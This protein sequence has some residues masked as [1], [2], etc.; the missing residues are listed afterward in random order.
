MNNTG[1]A[2]DD[3][4]LI[5]DLDGTLVKTDLLIESYFSAAT[6]S[7]WHHITVLGTLLR[8][9][10]QLK[11]YLASSST[12]D[13]GL[14]PYDE[15][16]LALIS[17]A[18][19]E[20]RRVYLATAS[21]QRHAEGVAAHLG[22]FDG[23]FSSDAKTNLSGKKKARLLVETFGARCFDYAGN[24]PADMAVWEE[25]RKAY[26]ANSSP[27]LARKV[28]RLGIPVEHL[29]RRTPVLR[30][31]L[32][33]LRV[34]QYAKNV[35]VFVP[36]LTAHAYSP[37]FLLKALLAFVAFCLC[38]SSVYILNDLLDLDA[39]RQHPG[40]RKRAFASGEI[41]I[42]HGIIAAP[43]LLLLAFSCAFLTSLPFAGALAG[44]FALTLA[45]SLTLKRKLLLDVV[46]LALLY[47]I[48]V[49]AGAVA[50]PVMVSE[51]LLA[52][53]MF[54]FTALA[55]VKRYVELSLRLDK[56]LPDPANRNYQLADLPIVG[57]L[58]AASGFNA[59]TIFALYISSPAVSTL[60]RHPERLWLICPILLYWIGRT[61]L[62]AHR[63]LLD[64]DPILFALRDPVSRLAGVLTLAI[65]LLAS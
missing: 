62:L 34:H 47:T 29:E 36:V 41:P 11:A 21:N 22:L 31:W 17:R 7:L 18:R 30:A 56:E 19:A 39:D 42:L 13:Y 44:Y 1:S 59:V 3:F 12:V 61:I 4:P 26:V 5:V 65:V 6:G 16:V 45:Y 50:L 2:I 24:G 52:F 55:L 48:R 46:I 9:K 54:I 63:R 40:K 25:A 8:G 43:L 14:L 49:I 57:A 37:H 60:Y 35:L 38:A 15:A 64:D 10:A 58:A 27:G 20:G 53:S 33:A 28:D 32:K 51:W 23:V